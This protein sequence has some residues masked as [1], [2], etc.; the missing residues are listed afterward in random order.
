MLGQK[1]RAHVACLT[2]MMIVCALPA[3]AQARMSRAERAVVKKIN[4]L[5]AHRG[6]HRV[7]RDRRLARAADV[8][9]R[10]MLRA[11]F[12]AHPSSNGTSTYDRVRRYRRS[13]LI[14][15]TLAYMPVRGNT[16]PRSI[17]NMWINSPG[18]LEVMTTGRFRR[19]GVSK[20]VG[21]LWGTRVT[22]WTADFAS[23]H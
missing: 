21:E 1:W 6:L 2:L 23:R 5:R 16:S 8:H 10:D 9:S 19:V 20:R 18:H 15:E 12:F 7:H 17:V 13:N 4:R 11:N 3:V 22:M 14:G